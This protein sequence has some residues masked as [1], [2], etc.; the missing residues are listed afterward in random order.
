MTKKKTFYSSLLMIIIWRLWLF[1]FAALGTLY[2]P[3]IVRF[4]AGKYGYMPYLFW[5][6][7]RLDGY[8][9]MEIAQRGYQSL[10]YGFFPLYPLLIHI[11][12][13]PFSNLSAY[14][15]AG[16]LISTVSFL[17][18]VYFIYKLLQLDGFEKYFLWLLL[19][20]IAFPTSFYYITVYND[21]LFL[22]LASASLYF[23]R[24][25]KWLASSF[26][27]FFAT[28]ARL[29]GLALFPF[30]LAEYISTA[31]WSWKK[32]IFE[33]RKKFTIKKIFISKI[34]YSLFV[35]LGLIFYLV[36]IQYH[37]G[38]FLALFSSMS[39][40]NQDRLVI[41]LQVIW[42]YL[43]IFSTVDP[44]LFVYW[45]AVSEL[46]F[47]LFYVTMMIFSFKKIRLS[48]WI[49]FVASISIPAF[50]G[51]FQG[52][53]RYGLHLYP[54]FLSLVL[55]LNKRPKIIKIIYFVISI[56]LLILATGLYTRGHFIA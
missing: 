46:A 20:I 9:Y 3:F 32:I 23:A 6:W 19:V 17:L 4:T 48:Y 28:L 51:T 13:T 55:F 26:L 12:A 35:P 5:I 54:F 1:V 8:Q 25:R 2:I 50:T 15:I 44:H 7:G 33:I 49:F 30:I 38:S 21:S 41:P 53:P 16:Q 36:Y 39:L 18:A 45:V 27:G 34:Y 14:I 52:M 40:W 47:F 10:E 22:V 42:R 37:A 56:A 24:Q 31:G 43:K 11:F 29:N